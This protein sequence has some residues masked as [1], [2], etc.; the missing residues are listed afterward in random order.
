MKL[1]CGGAMV[2]LL[3]IRMMRDVGYL[4]TLREDPSFIHGSRPEV[5]QKVFLTLCRRGQSFLPPNACDLT[6][7][8]LAPSMNQTPAHACQRPTDCLLVPNVSIG[9]I[10]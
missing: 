2:V 8:V 6:R 9:A 4:G 3:D 10:S 5:P 7:R 1:A